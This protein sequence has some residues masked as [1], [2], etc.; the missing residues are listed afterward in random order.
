MRQHPCHANNRRCCYVAEVFLLLSYNTVSMGNRIPTFRGNVIF[1]P[2]VATCP[3]GRFEATCYPH[4]QMALRP[5][6]HSKQRV[7]LIFKWLYVLKDIRSNVLSSSSNAKICVLVKMRRVR[8]LKRRNPISHRRNVTKQ[9][10]GIL[11]HTAA[12]TCLL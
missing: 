12:K 2:Q 6:R 11:N 1:Y 8:T 7:I 9:E 10:I 4:L 5:K 3:R